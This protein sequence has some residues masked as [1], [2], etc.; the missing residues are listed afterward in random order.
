VRTL[1]PYPVPWLVQLSRWELRLAYALQ[2]VEWPPTRRGGR[3]AVEIV[4][5][6][7]RMSHALA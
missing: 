7:A 6:N 1:K 3:V 5:G 2:S 4:A